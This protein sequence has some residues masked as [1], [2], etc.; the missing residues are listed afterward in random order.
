MLRGCV[1][2]TR[3]A[4]YTGEGPIGYIVIVE[5]LPTANLGAAVSGIITVQFQ[6]AVLTRPGP[7]PLS[8]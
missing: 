7:H 1:A 4:R 6:S 5:T 8:L 3:V 2:D